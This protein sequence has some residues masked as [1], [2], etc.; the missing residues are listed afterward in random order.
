MK[1][2]QN[3]QVTYFNSN[4][5]IL[6]KRLLRPTFYSNIKQLS[7]EAS[8]MLALWHILAD[9]LKVLNQVHFHIKT[10]PFS[11]N[12]IS[13]FYFLPLLLRK[14]EP[15][16]N[17]FICILHIIFM[18]SFELDTRTIKSKCITFFLIFF[19]FSIHI[20]RGGKG[21]FPFKLIK[22]LL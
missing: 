18:V 15:W 9:S 19:S 5:V 10:F 16:K 20:I 7:F 21:I 8:N 13:V 12:L 22:T 6:K 1:H 2:N 11:C 4:R 17:V 14:R 3:Y